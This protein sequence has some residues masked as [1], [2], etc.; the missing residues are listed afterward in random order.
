MHIYIIYMCKVHILLVV[1]LV[2]ILL[3]TSPCLVQ[4]Y[5]IPMLLFTFCILIPLSVVHLQQ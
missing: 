3:Y 1:A 2:L 5:L 4:I